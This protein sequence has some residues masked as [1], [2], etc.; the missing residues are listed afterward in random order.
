MYWII[1]YPGHWTIYNVESEDSRTLTDNEVLKVREE[2]PE[3][4]A[5]DVASF[6][7]EQ[8]DSI[9]DKP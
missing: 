1:K 3:L 2:I 6:Y 7:V 5:S 9:D 4:N 8:I